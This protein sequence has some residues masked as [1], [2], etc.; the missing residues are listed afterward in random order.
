MLYQKK[1]ASKQF[2]SK[3][4]LSCGVGRDRTGDTRIFSPLLYRLSYRTGRVWSPEYRLYKRQ[5]PFRAAN[6][7][8]GSLIQAL[9]TVFLDFSY[10]GFH[11]GAPQY[12]IIQNSLFN[13]HYSHLRNSTFP[14]GSPLR[15]IKNRCVPFFATKRL[16]LQ[17]IFSNV[18]RSYNSVASPYFNIQNSIF[19]SSS[20]F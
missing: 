4:Y 19:N 8:S 20:S 14:L 9:S 12:P 18:H 13:I 16:S 2:A 10:R 5:P 15:G 7:G 3:P 17:D 1:K 11:P 6:I